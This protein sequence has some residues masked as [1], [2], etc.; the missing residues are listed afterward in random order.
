MGASHNVSGELIEMPDLKIRVRD[1]ADETLVEDERFLGRPRCS[2]AKR[3][4]S[5]STSKS[6]AERLRTVEL[7]F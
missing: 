2:P 4:T 1:E 6:R 5:A 3:W 7:S